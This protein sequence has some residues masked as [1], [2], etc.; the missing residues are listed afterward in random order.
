MGLAEG[1]VDGAGLGHAH[2]GPVQSC[3]RDEKLAKTRRTPTEI[4][5]TNRMVSRIGFA[6]L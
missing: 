4:L 2:L 5:E 6:C 3:F 1:A